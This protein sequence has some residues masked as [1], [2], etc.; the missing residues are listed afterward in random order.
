MAKSKDIVIEQGKTF[1][2]VIRWENENLVYKPISAI[3][4]AAPVAI[5]SATHGA[6]DGW[7]VAIVSVK[8]MTQLNAANAPP[9]DK[10]YIPATKI[11]D[12]IIELNSVNAA[13]YKAYTSGGYIQYYEPHDLAD[14]SARMK[15]KDKVGGTTLLSSEGVTP[16]IDIA[17]DNT[18]KTIT[19]T[20]SAADTAAITTWKKGVYELEGVDGTS[21]EVV[22]SLL[23]GTVTLVEEIVTA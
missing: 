19:V 7:N 15:I 6:P 5:T 11:S 13:E 17:L 14:S 18:A 3:T 16:A 12:S 1:R 9:K 22:Y 23:T 4:Q 2:L 8:G 10:D 20:I 21:P